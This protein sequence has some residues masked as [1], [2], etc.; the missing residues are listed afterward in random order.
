MRLIAWRLFYI[1]FYLGFNLLA[2]GPNAVHCG[3]VLFARTYVYTNHCILGVKRKEFVTAF[4]ITN[5]IILIIT[6]ILLT[7]GKVINIKSFLPEIR[8]IG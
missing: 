3:F 2:S 5:G 8:G 1:K 4:A 6:V 7:K